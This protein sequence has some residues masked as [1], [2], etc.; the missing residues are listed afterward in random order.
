MAVDQ[1]SG[2]AT[3]ATVVVEV[4]SE[5]QSSKVHTI[6][7]KFPP[8][9]PLD[10]FFLCLSTVPHHPLGDDRLTGCTVGKALFLSMMFLTV[11]GCVLLMLMWL[12]K[13][14]RGM[15]GPLERGCVAQ[16]KHPN[17]V[18]SFGTQTSSQVAQMKGQ[19]TA[20]PV[21][22]LSSRKLVFPDRWCNN[23]NF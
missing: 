19:K 12:K 20:L 11:L 10:E 15:K 6:Y 5:G 2:D 23:M 4:L 7:H 8:R 13:K 1:E 3:F 18:R 16:C 17:V 9:E 22:V 21:F 14:H